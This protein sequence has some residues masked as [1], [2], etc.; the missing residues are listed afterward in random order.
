VRVFVAGFQHETNSF[1]A[2]AA[3]WAAFD[4][5]DFFPRYSHGAQMLTAHASS[6][7]PMSGF[8]EGA[9]QANWEVV[10]SCWAGASPS[11]PVKRD[12]FERIASTIV[13]DLAAARTLHRI[14]GIYLDLH[15]AAVC[16]H[17]DAP[18]AELVRRLRALVGAEVPVVVS[19]D[20]HANVDEDLVGAADGVVAYRTYPHI[21]MVETGRRASAML[22][23]RASRVT[24]S[25]VIRRIPFLIPIATQST[26]SGPAKTLYRRLDELEA[27]FGGAPGATL[28]F[29]A[30]DVP[31]CGPTVWAYGAHAEEIV[32]ALSAQIVA[33]GPHWR[34][35][36]VEAHEAV[37]TAIDLAGSAAGPVIIADVQDNPGAGADSNT[38]GLLHALL[39]ADTGQRWPSKVALG[40]LNDPDA[41]W[42][43]HEAG[44]GATVDLSLGKSVATPSGAFSEPPLAGRFTVRSLHDGKATLS[45]PMMTGARI[46]AG[47]CACLEIGGVLVAVSSAKTQM[48]D[49]VL[50]RMLRIE[51][52]EMRILVN[53][54]AVHFRADFAP[55]AAAVVLAKAKGPMAADPADLP[56]KHLRPEVARSPPG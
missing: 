1:A 47:P 38:T 24:E 28:G 9:H 53:K 5:G 55:I 25:L 56:W 42:A 2:G 13:D 29:P 39:Q 32:E 33:A 20:L 50:Y 14:D 37:R 22:E 6:G 21:D 45:G 8:L 49:R 27:R 46:D 16:E 40:L 36:L 34:P 35:H 41:A 51:P 31:H 52:A 43:A 48:L 7:M 17:L 4:R 11:A 23:R 44:V 26:L 10:G 30:A 12:T 18:E 19:L 15:G 54:S 3:D